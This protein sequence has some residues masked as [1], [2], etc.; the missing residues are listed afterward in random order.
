[1]AKKLRMVSWIVLTLFG[2]LLLLGAVGSAATAMTRGPDQF[3]TVTMDELT[4]GN[5][6]VM[7]ILYARR[8]TAAAYASGF[9]VLFLLIVLIPY[10]RGEV[11]AW[12]ALLIGTCVTA[13]LYILRV[14]TIGVTIGAEI[15]YMMLGFVVVALLLDVARLRKSS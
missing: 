8:L 6:E 5:N 15:G 12:W 13:G 1:M 11:W 9:S 3:G 2:V 7:G 10:R 4:G 14:P